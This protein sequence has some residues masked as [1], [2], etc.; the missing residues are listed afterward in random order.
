MPCSPCKTIRSEDTGIDES[1]G[2]EP[3]KIKIRYNGAFLAQNAAIICSLCLIHTIA[4]R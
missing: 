2:K 4:M 3:S 1:G